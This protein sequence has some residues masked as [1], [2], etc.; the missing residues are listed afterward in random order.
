MIPIVIFSL[1]IELSIFLGFAIAYHVLSFHLIYFYS[2][3]DI[4]EFFLTGHNPSFLKFFLFHFED[5]DDYN[6]VDEQK[7]EEDDDDETNVKW[8]CVAIMIMW[9]S[10]SL[11]NS[12]F[13]FL[14]S[15]TNFHNFFFKQKFSQSNH[16][17]SFYSLNAKL[18]FFSVTSQSEEGK[19]P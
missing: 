11:I 5:A 8:I 6:N 16:L 1:Q 15:F 3:E 18:I 12:F 14:I 4:S 9:S 17:M 13:L 10:F 19:C 7:E 2:F